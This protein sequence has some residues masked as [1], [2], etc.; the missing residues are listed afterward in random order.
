MAYWL[1]Y[2]WECYA[3]HSV[4]EAVAVDI[5]IGILNCHIDN[6]SYR[7]Q[8]EYGYRRI[9]GGNRTDRMDIAIVDKATNSCVCAMEFKLST[10]SNG[11]VYSD[12]KKL[13][14]LPSSIYRIAILISQK[15][16][17]ITKS[18]LNSKGRAIGN[19]PTIPGASVIRAAKAKESDGQTNRA[20]RVICVELQ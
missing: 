14:A 15:E 6:S 17:A 18:L 9:L 16:N 4:M 1:G 19:L 8:Q 3:G 2:R 13:N 5:A 12:L 10:D 20:F 11:S 7:I